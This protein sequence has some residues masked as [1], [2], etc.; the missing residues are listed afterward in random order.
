ME[1]KALTIALEHDFSVP[2][3]RLYEAWIKEDDLKNW[4]H[5]SENKLVNVAQ[6]VEEGG[7]IRYEFEGQNGKSSLIITGKYKEVKPNEKLVYSW[8]WDVS[9]EG[10]EKSNHE[11]IIEFVANGDQSK[12][13]VAQDNFENDESITPHKEGWVK[14]LAALDEYLKS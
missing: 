9:A 4:W 14:A 10:V 11:L 8:N 7:D 5:P 3:E 13:K 1:D 6:T 2:A 12:I